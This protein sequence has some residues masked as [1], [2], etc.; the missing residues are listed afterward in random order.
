METIETS[1]INV[2]TQFTIYTISK[3]LQIELPFLQ[4]IKNMIIRDVQSIWLPNLKTV[5]TNLEFI[6]NSCVDIDLGTL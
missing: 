6:E 3:D 5:E 4:D 2:R 1:L